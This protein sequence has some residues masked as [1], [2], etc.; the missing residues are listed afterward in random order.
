MWSSR[1]ETIFGRFDQLAYATGAVSKLGQ[2]DFY[3]TFRSQ[4]CPTPSRRSAPPLTNL[5]TAFAITAIFRCGLTILMRFVRN[6]NHVDPCQEHAAPQ[7]I[8]THALMAVPIQFPTSSRPV[9]S[10]IRLDIAGKNHLI[11]HSTENMCNGEYE[12]INGM[13]RRSKSWHDIAEV[14]ECMHKE[15]ATRAA[16]VGMI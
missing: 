3:L 8:F 10:A 5:K 7:N 1:R 11:H 6:T 2:P 16:L 14:Q 13:M 12:R 4:V 15:A 9:G